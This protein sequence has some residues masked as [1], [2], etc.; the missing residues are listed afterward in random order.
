MPYVVLVTLAALLQYL[1]FGWRVGMARSRYNIAAP[2]TTGNE[3]F[4]RYYRVHMNTL[5]QLVLFLPLLWLFAHLVSFNYAAIL[6]AV[7]VIGRALYAIGYVRDPKKR[8]AGFALTALP[9]MAMLITLLVW[10]VRTLLQGN[11]I[12]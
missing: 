6:G 11:G 1:W 12:A 4:E 8:S 5:E 7:F 10:T 2:A 9:S 3:I